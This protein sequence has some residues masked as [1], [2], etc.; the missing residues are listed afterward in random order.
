MSRRNLANLENFVALPF[1]T[2]RLEGDMYWG[3]AVGGKERREGGGGRRYFGGLM[4]RMWR[5]QGM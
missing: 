5:M 3:G 1:R 2:C 4:S